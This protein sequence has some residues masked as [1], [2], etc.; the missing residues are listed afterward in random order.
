MQLKN[1]KKIKNLQS[2]VQEQ[3]KLYVI[4]SGLKSG[5]MPPS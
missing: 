3:L 4:D 5:D 1:L 2:I